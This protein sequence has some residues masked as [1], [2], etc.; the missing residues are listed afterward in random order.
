MKFLKIS[1]AAAGAL[2]ATAL[3]LMLGLYVYS[4]VV[5]MARGLT[6]DQRSVLQWSEIG[7]SLLACVG[8]IAWRVRSRGAPQ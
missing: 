3:C 6:P 2:A 7:V 4:H 5:H 8:A 1:L